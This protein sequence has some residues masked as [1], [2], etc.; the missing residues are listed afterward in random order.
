MVLSDGWMEL[1]VLFEII[2][3]IPYC[4]EKRKSTDNAAPWINME[5]L[6]SWS[7][8]TTCILKP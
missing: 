1:L 8:K 4:W 6:S 2:S 3:E 7:E 5:V